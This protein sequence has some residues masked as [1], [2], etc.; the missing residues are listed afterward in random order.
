[1]VMLGLGNNFHGYFIMKTIEGT[2]NSKCYFIVRVFLQVA[3]LYTG[4]CIFLGK[5]MSW[6]SLQLQPADDKLYKRARFYTSILMAISM[7]VCGFVIYSAR[8]LI[9]VKLTT[10]TDLVRSGV[11]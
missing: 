7:I 2:F 3:I 8:K 4:V 10:H 5:S 1:M 6:E 11:G 9:K